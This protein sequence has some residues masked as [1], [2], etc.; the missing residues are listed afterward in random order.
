MSDSKHSASHPMQGPCRVDKCGS[1]RDGD[2]FLCGY[3]RAMQKG[4]LGDW[5]EGLFAEFRRNHEGDMWGTLIEASRTLRAADDRRE[6]LKQLSRLLPT[7][8]D[9]PYD[10]MQY[11]V[12]PARR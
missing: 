3:H 4:D 2:D 10:P 11:E 7:L 8:S 6:F 1:Q 9:L 12:A 5:R